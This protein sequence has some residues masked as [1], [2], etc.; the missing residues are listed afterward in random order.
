MQ[1]ASTKLDLDQARSEL[2]ITFQTE[3]MRLT[4]KLHVQG[5]A[6]TSAAT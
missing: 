5:A 1:V 3:G 6:K 2:S 4:N